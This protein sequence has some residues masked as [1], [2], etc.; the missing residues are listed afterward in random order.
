V[1][2]SEPGFELKS[3]NSAAVL[4]L[5]WVDHEQLIATVEYVGLSASREV[6]TF[7]SGVPTQLFDAMAREWRGWA[8]TKQWE[9]LEGELKLTATR[10]RTGHI[11]VQVD[12]HRPGAWELR[13]WLTLE[14]GQLDRIAEQLRRFSSA[15]RA[16]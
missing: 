5:Q 16:A 11:T 15:G 9:S 10:D 14:A 12:L 4:R 2:Q 3:T 8:G 7:M 13:V 6:Y 1:V